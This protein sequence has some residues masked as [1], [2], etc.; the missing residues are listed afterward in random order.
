MS[1]L[2]AIVMLLSIFVPFSPA[3]VVQASPKNDQVVISQ[4]YGGGGNSGAVYTH[5][6]IELFNPTD[7]AVDLTGWKVRYASATGNFT[8]TTS[9][10]GIIG[11]HQYLLIQQNGGSTG[12]PLPAPDL[13][14]N[15]NLSGTNGKVDLVNA[16][17]ERIDLIGYGTANDYETGA[18]AALSNGTAAIRKELAAG[19]SGNR[20][21]DTD[22]NAADFTIAAPEPRN[23]AYA[24]TPSNPGNSL[25]PVTANPEPNA[26]PVG[27]EITLSPPTVTASVYAAVYLPDDLGTGFQLV[28]GPLVINVPT[29]VDAYAA[30]DGVPD[31]PVTS[32]EYEVLTKTP[33]AEAR[34]KAKGDNVWTEGIITHIEGRETYIEDDTAGI[35][36]YD[37]PLN[38]GVGDRVSV[39]GVM[40]I[41]NNLQEIKPHA[42]L[43]HEV[44]GSHV[45]SPE[46]LRIS[47]AD[48][49]PD[50][51]E[52][53]EARLVSLDDVSIKSENRAGE[54]TAVQGGHEFIIYS[55]LSKLE[56]GKTFSRVTGVVKQYGSIYELIP[57]GD[58]ALIEDMFS[59]IARPGAGP[60]ITGSTVTLSSPTTGASIYYTVD[61]I[62]PTTASTLYSAP[63]QVDRD[64]TIKAIVVSGTDVSKVYDFAYTATE[65]PR[66]ADIQGKGHMSPYNGQTVKDIEG[67]VTQ[68]GYTSSNGS[69]KGFYIQDTAPDSNPNTSDAIFVYSTN[70]SRPQVG[71]VVS[72]TGKVAE[73]NEGSSTNL[74]TT[75]IELQSY[76]TIEEKKPLPEPVT[77]G[78]GGRPIPASIIDNDGFQVFD[79]DEDAIDFY[80]SLEGMRVRLPQPTI[81]S[82]Y[83]T[84]NGTYNIPTRVENDV[85]DV[86]TPAGGLVLK[87]QR[88]FN[89]QRLLVAY[90]NPGQEVSTGD[91]FADDV[92]GVIGYTSGNFKVIPGLGGLPAINSGSF[93]QEVSTIEV[94]DDQLRVATYNIEN[95]YPGVGS[96]KINKLAESMVRN[97]K[98]PD[99]ITLVEV[100]DNNGEKN[101]GT[102]AADQSYQSLINAIRAAGGPAYSYTD[103]E[104][105][106][107]ND[108]GAPGA[109]IRV[110]FLYNPE[111]VQLSDSILG[112]K[113]TSTDAVAYD[114]AKDQ[115]NYNPGRIDPMNSAFEAS[116]KPLAAQFEFRGEKVIVIAN[117]FN[118]KSGDQGPFGNTQPPLLSSEAQRHQIAAVVNGFVKDVLKGNPEANIIAMGDLNDFQFTPTGTILKGNELDNLI[119]TLPLEEQ[120]TY[121]YDGNSQVLDHILVSKNLTRS[122][123]VDVVHLNADFAPSK[124][125]VSDHDPV[126]AQIDL[127]GGVPGGLPLTI[128]HTN[129]T[130]AN[131]DTVSSPDN[132]ARRVAAI[133]EEKA[134]AINPLLVDAGD[135]FSGTLYFNQYLGQA[136]LEFMNLVQYDAMTFGNHEF[137]KG[138]EV[139]NKFIENASFSFVSANVNFSTDPLL[140]EKFKNEVSRNAKAGNI[141]PAM[142]TEVGGQQVGMFGLTTED[143][144]NISSPGLVTFD[145]AVQKAKDTV[146]MLQNEGVNKIIVLSHLGYDVDVNLAKAVA[147]I[148][149]VVGGHS[150]TKLDQAVV[151]RTGS[152]PKLIVQT[153][154][155][156]QFLGK[157][158]VVFNDEGV[159]QEWNSRL[160]SIDEKDADGQYVIKPDQEA[161]D[162]LN[163]KYKPGVQQLMQA[164]VG[165]TEVKLNGVRADVRTKETNLG[166]LIADGML[167]AAQAAGTNAVIA[168]QN[169]GGIRESIEAGKVTMGGVMTVLP[170]NNDLVTI[171]L[172]GQEIKE[173][174]E[175]GVSKIPAQDGRFPHIAGMRFYYDSTKSPGERVLRIE[176]KGKNGYEPINP[177]QTY[178]VATNA[179]TAKGGDFYASLERA[180]LEGRVNLLYLPDYEVFSNYVKKI[181][182][183]TSA[184]SAVEGRIVAL[185]GAPLPEE[186][187]KPGTPGKPSKPG[188]SGNSNK[189]STSGQTTPPA[190]TPVPGSTTP[191]EPGKVQV[192]VQV[193]QGE[194]TG[195]VTGAAMKEAL[196]QPSGGKVTI[197]AASPEPVQSASITVDNEALQAW[198]AGSDAQVLNVVTPLGSYDLPKQEVHLQALANETGTDTAGVRLVI[199]V[200]VDADA[201]QDAASKGYRGLQAVKYSV[202]ARGEDGKT[203]ALNEYASYVKRSILL[204]QPGPSASLAVVRLDGGGGYVPV[205]FKANGQQIDIYSQANGTYLVIENAV[206]FRDISS[207][208]SKAD[209]ESLA[210]KLIVTGRT[211]QTYVPDAPV[212]RAEFAALIV[213][214]LGLSASEGTGSF[215]DVAASDWHA[216]QIQ[217]A[218]KAG[219]V[220]GYAD[221]TFRPDRTITREEMAVMVFKALEYTGYQRGSAPQAAFADGADL[222]AW[223]EEAVQVLNGLD[224]VNGDSRKRFVPKSNTTRGESAAV[225]NRMIR[226]LT[227][228]K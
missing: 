164:E 108:G 175:N 119:E 221:G 57:L 94:K 61:G 216:G 16:A 158:E 112:K 185:K 28:N 147:G 18:T 40:D 176:V 3:S 74:T 34:G 86:I 131:L 204:E 85:P 153:G 184:T 171:T 1:L 174:L 160:I 132:I 29:R 54:Y 117:H 73:Y 205:P 211:Q 50:Q 20:G 139:L 67:I 88:N 218:V 5:D 38:A 24:D 106:N 215:K 89:P 81:I 182:T 122:A 19:P 217:A 123:K 179:F 161:L 187:G 151:D 113:G 60:I 9:L 21:L 104:P 219:I 166:N 226:E 134:G 56:P 70:N 93:E 43:P 75:Q 6:F 45:G 41:Y 2:L 190:T 27:T 22:N 135:V 71:D 35:V 186:P 30:M 53:Y 23:S 195:T 69:I 110:G 149:I 133:R 55:G 163:T 193:E 156:G 202:T 79:P 51:G 150:H 7:Q 115:L 172:T 120:Y 59:V 32:F 196:K 17:D 136:D 12:N 37:Y 95:F 194:A 141:Y 146:A 103:I 178:E 10:S 159:L 36:L 210:A 177:S 64:M 192:Q 155:K 173:A 31:G 129:D 91:T 203:V 97:L 214:A 68:Y 124:G 209:V 142:I 116:R 208:W 52:T 223:A 227:Y 128:L 126:V 189:P 77:L 165:L 76:R 183:I 84:S 100:Q 180:Y 25:G 62:E 167:N 87:E 33:V 206:T 98:S 102:T 49:A 222:G 78:K 225:L 198:L 63:I 39:A 109:N 138:S 154:E 66:I 127:Q 13:T 169:G 15:L 8:N 220:G 143:T 99:I 145:N 152:A 224:I 181:G 118:S 4:V 162:I 228:E 105:V 200:A 188:D 65:Q 199:G 107:N 168:L 80:E 121:T 114:A 82:P 197:E 207:H 125:R 83:W 44:T 47:G 170:F 42:L 48:L 72:V 46:P 101:D 191:A 148:D 212:T 96:A 58:D 157:L 11:P 144:A 213:K 140:R 90:G 14:G 201:L 111:R 26:W 92:I 137:D 130:H